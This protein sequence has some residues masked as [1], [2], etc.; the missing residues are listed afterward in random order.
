MIVY[1][2][3]MHFFK[4]LVEMKC[5]HDRRNPNTSPPAWGASAKT[6]KTKD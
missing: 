5:V 1:V 6:A 2:K 4:V 3:Y